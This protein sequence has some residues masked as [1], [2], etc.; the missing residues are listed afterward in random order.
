VQLARR[1]PTLL[2]DQS[3]PDVPRITEVLHRHGVDYLVIGGVAT[4]PTEPSDPPGISTA[5]S[6]ARART[7]TD[8]KPPC[9]S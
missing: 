3:R 1:L 9:A 5:W 6:G 8:W 7:S 2:P 4:R